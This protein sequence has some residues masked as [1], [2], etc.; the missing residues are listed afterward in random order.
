[1]WSIYMKIA[2]C[3]DELSDK[4]ALKEKLCLVT[5]SNGIT[6]EI[7]YFNSGESFE[8]QLQRGYRCD[9]AILD[10]YMKDMNGIETAKL[11]LKYDHNVS[12]AFSSISHFHAVEA[13]Y[14]GALHYILKPVG[15]EDLQT[16]FE[17]YFLK[18]S[19][20]KQTIV[21]STG[22][23]IFTFI[24]RN[25]IKIQSINRGIDV[26][27]TTKRHPDWVP[28]SFKEAELLLH[29]KDFLK[30]SRGI[31]INMM[32]IQNMMSDY[33]TLK[34]GTQ[35]LLSRREKKEIFSRYHDYVFKKME[36][37]EWG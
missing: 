32:S 3:E 7:E 27:T 25:V 22:R 5:N 1:M 6:A 11:L 14:L 8:G 24:Q 21:F 26:Y 19:E 31:M 15:E 12:I 9:L 23:Q 29:Q 37:G 28:V 30:V 10:I 20:K 17:R 2:V 13:F 4:M 16:L 33:C 34:D 36:H 18:K 35:V